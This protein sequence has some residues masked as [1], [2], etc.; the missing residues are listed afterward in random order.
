MRI[1]PFLALATVVLAAAGAG[2]APS[3]DVTILRDRWGVPHIFESGRGAS[4]RSAYA[5][6]YAQAEDRLFEMDIL[7]RAGTGRLAE[8]LGSSYLAMDEVVRRDLYTHDELAQFFARL[9]PSD[10]LSTEAYRDGVNAYIAKVTLDPMLLP[11]EFGG[12][13]PEPWDVTDSAAIAALQFVVF[14]ANGGQEV[15]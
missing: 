2:A 15:L 8:M 13:P 1:G 11:F 7:R 14:G 5:N 6:G 4:D 9:S 12:V 10:Q 3:G